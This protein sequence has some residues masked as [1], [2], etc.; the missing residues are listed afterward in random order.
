MKTINEMREKVVNIFGLEH[1]NTQ[2]FIEDCEKNMSISYLNWK[3][4]LMVLLDK[5]NH[6]EIAHALIE[7]NHSKTVVVEL[8]NKTFDF[9]ATAFMEIQRAVEKVYTDCKF[10][11]IL[12]IIIE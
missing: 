6:T 12:D 11:K 9:Y 10:I 8:K 2:F 3:F 1:F 7:I 4:D 5:I